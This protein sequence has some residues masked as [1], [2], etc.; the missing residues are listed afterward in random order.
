VW[1]ECADGRRSAKVRVAT[2][3]GTTTALDL[4][5]DEPAWV[6]GVVLRG[7][8]RAP[9]DERVSWQYTAIPELKLGSD[10]PGAPVTPDEAGRF[11][12]GP[13]APGDYVVVLGGEVALETT[14]RLVG[15]QRAQVT[16]DTTRP[17]AVFRTTFAGEPLEDLQGIC[18]FTLDPSGASAGLRVHARRVGRSEFALATQH[19][20]VLLALDGRVQGARGTLFAVVDGAAL[21]GSTVAVPMASLVI[22][23]DR[24]GTRPPPRA[25]LLG[26]GEWSLDRLVVHFSP[27]VSE[28]REDGLAFHGIPAGARVRLVGHDARGVEHTR[29]LVVRGGL[30]MRVSFP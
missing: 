23:A 24:A 20:R 1:A 15:G 29:E 27:L 28:S 16:F 18:A 5:V 2:T 4:V 30:P 14:V 22:D 26:L 25:Y 10:G 21:D 9:A 13:F 3:P 8:R 6:E 19:E 11:A 17:E 12:L 7:S